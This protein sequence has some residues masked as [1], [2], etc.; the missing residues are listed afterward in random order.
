MHCIDAPCEAVCPTG[1]TYTREDG[2]VAVNYDECIACGACATACPYGARCTAANDSWWFGA[3]EPAPYESEGIVRE[4]PALEK[5]V[6]CYPRLEAGLQP[7]CVA[8]CPGKARVFGDLDDPASPISAA[9]AEAGD[10]AY[11]VPGSKFYY[12][13]FEDM[14][15][16]MLP[17]PSSQN[18]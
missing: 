10:A 17:A 1:A 18:N 9:L 11:N 2:I 5:C 8:N 16:G 13:G 14:P 12:I 7:A 6:F 15:A 3:S 4:K